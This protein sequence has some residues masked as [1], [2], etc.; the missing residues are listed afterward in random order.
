MPEFEPRAVP[1][2]IPLEPPSEVAGGSGASVVAQRAVLFEVYSLFHVAAAW[3]RVRTSDVIYFSRRVPFKDPPPWTKRLVTR[4]VRLLN[5]R[6]ELR[7]LAVEDL[8]DYLPLNARA[9]DWLEALGPEIC[10]TKAYSLVRSII[11][12]DMLIRFYQGALV[13]QAVNWKLLP[14]VADKLSLLHPSLTVVP[15]WD[16]TQVHTRPDKFTVPVMDRPRVEDLMPVVVRAS[17]VRMF[18][19]TVAACLQLVAVPTAIL[20]AK[21]RHGIP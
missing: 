9:V 17:G 13:R 5:P 7:E 16:T 18:F 12:D 2:T 20:L 10:N 4:L 19:R 6:A 1:S 15:E 3:R 8:L 14:L 21:L 11:R